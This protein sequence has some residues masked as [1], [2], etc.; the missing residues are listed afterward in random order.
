MNS[1]CLE[2]LIYLPNWSHESSAVTHSRQHSYMCSLEWESHDSS[3]HF[4]LVMKVARDMF[5]N[6]VRGIK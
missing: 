3:K 2:N 4:V 5:E 6:Y 1:T